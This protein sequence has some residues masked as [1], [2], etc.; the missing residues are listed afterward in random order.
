MTKFTLGLWIHVCRPLT[1]TLVVDDFG[2][3][4]E[5]DAHANHLSKTLKRNYNVTVDWKGELYVGIKLKWDYN[6]R[7]LY[8]H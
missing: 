6:K 5:A 1:F 7:T 2:V 8:T 3:K 4:F